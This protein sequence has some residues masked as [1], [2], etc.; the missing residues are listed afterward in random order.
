MAKLKR[1]G[2]IWYNGSP[3]SDRPGAGRRPEPI[4]TDVPRD[5]AVSENE[6]FRVLGRG[7][8]LWDGTPGFFKVSDE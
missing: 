3:T 2:F 7:Y 4:E 5:R 1:P 6:G 8:R